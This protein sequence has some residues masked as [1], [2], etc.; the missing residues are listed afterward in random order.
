MASFFL[1]SFPTLPI[2]MLVSRSH[3]GKFWV[4]K[5]IPTICSLFNIPRG[6]LLFGICPAGNLFPPSYVLLLGSVSIAC[7]LSNVSKSM[8][9]HSVQNL[10]ALQYGSHPENLACHIFWN[11]LKILFNYFLRF[12]SNSFIRL[13]SFVYS[14]LVLYIQLFLLLFPIAIVLCIPHDSTLLG[15]Q[16]QHPQDSIYNIVLFIK[17]YLLQS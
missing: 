15:S 8:F 12:T 6:V 3:P 5:P 14:I 1:R 7:K 9:L 13:T 11:I 17:C 16:F 4:C 10:V 2:P